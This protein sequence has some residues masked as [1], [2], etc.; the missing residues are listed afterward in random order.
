[1]CL[2][3]VNLAKD[4]EPILWISEKIYCSN[5][6]SPVLCNDLLFTVSD[7][8][9]ITCLDA[10]TGKIVW[11]NQIE[12]EYFASPVAIGNFI[13]F[14]NSN[15]LT[16]VI[17]AAREYKKISESDLSEE[18]FASFAPVNKQLFIRTEKHLYRIQ[19]D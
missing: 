13:Y 7:G 6:A 19:Q 16:T 4:K 18:T 17:A 5:I 8:G 2:S 12:G 10:N 3:L 14:C 9:D 1:M 11:E 15:G